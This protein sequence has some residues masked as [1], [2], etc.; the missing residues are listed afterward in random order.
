MPTLFVGAKSL[1]KGAQIETQVI[2]HTGLF[3]LVDSDDGS[4]EVKE[5]DSP[6]YE[7]GQ[8]HLRFS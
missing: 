3:D 8:L 2:A 5:C 7:E 1:P 6:E 4:I